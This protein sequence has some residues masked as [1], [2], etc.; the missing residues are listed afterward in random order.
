MHLLLVPGLLLAMASALT[1]G[2]AQPA[3]DSLGHL[4]GTGSLFS[5]AAQAT[6]TATLTTGTTEVTSDATATAAS[7][8]TGTS[9]I[10]ATAT[11]T[12]SAQSTPVPLP[13]GEIPMQGNPLDP[14]FLFSAPSPPIGPYAWACLALMTALLAVSGYFLLIKRPEWKG[15][16]PV[17]HRAANK[18]GQVGLWV[19]I[20]GLLCLLFRV[21]TLDFFNM[22]IWLYLWALATLAAAGWFVY[23]LRMKYPKEAAK[24]QK[25]QRARQ[26]M[27]GS[28]SKSTVR[29][30]TQTKS[31]A[32]ASP[33]GDSVATT[34]SA[35]T[36]SKPPSTQS[37]PGQKSNKRGRRK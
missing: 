17:L 20:V 31:K 16:N 8:V 28:A 37:R 4:L 26:Y 2:P 30:T 35:P 3:I 32:V 13:V 1:S 19:S 34:T 9:G 22:R 36:M 7:T 21:V 5:I 29:Q 10:S 24:Y 12:G 6:T 18:W 27:P 15:T 14:A 23:W 33:T 11:I 25:S